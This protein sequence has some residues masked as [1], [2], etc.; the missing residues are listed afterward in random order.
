[1][2][3]KDIGEILENLEWAVFG[4]LKDADS[5]SG[6]ERFNQNPNR[7]YNLVPNYEGSNMVRPEAI[8]QRSVRTAPSQ[9]SP[10]RTNHYGKQNQVIEAIRNAED[11]GNAT[12]TRQESER[13]KKHKANLWVTQHM[14]NSKVYERRRNVW[15]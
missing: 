3:E 5:R 7:P 12:G 9:S 14:V 10:T 13:L 4:P 11:I 15:C 6:V 1:M 2:V 8:P